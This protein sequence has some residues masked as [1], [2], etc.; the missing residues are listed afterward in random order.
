VLEGTYE[1][2]FTTPPPH[3]ALEAALA[4]ASASAATS[5]RLDCAGMD[6]SHGPSL[7]ALIAAAEAGK[8][9]HIEELVLSGCQ[10]GAEGAERVCS[11]L[12]EF[13]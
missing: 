1:Q 6:L 10:L 3:A 4:S 5:T 12:V 11:L 13:L 9:L 2:V 8:L 7:D